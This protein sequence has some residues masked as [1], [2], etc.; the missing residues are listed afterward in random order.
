[1]K[2]SLLFICLFPIALFAQDYVEADSLKTLFD[3]SNNRKV[4]FDLAI[5]LSSLY[6][7]LAE[8]NL[9]EE[10]HLKAQSL[11]DSTNQY[12]LAQITSNHGLILMV[13][14]QFDLAEEKMLLALESARKAQA[15]SLII[16]NYEN[17]ALLYSLQSKV[18]LSNSYWFSCLSY[19]QKINDKHG[20]QAAYNGIGFNYTSYDE[21]DQSL[22]Y[23]QKAYDLA[24]ELD[25]INGMS[26]AQINIGYSHEMLGNQTKALKAYKR[27]LELHEILGVEEYVGYSY[28]LIGTILT[29]LNQLDSS[30]YYLDQSF[31]ILAKSNDAYGLSFVHFGYSV[32]NEKTGDFSSSLEHAKKSLQYSKE[33]EFTVNALKALFQIQNLHKNLGQYR[34]AYETFVNYIELRDSIKNPLNSKEIAG[35]E[36]KNEYQTLRLSDSLKFEQE[37]QLSNIQHNEELKRYWIYAIG[38]IILLVLMI[39]LLIMSLRNSK[40]RKRKNIE[41]QNKNKE[42]AIQK[43]NLQEIHF[44]LE[45]KNN[46]IIDSISYAKRIQSAILPS[47]KTIKEH[48]PQSFIL[49]QPKDIVAGDFYWLE[50]KN[51]TV[52]FAAADCT[53]HGVPGAMVSVVCNNGLNRSVREHQ[54]LDPGQI[55][56]NTREIVIAEFEKSEEDVKDGMDI[57]LCAWKGKELKYAGANNPLWIIRA[58]SDEIEEIKADKQ[59]IGKFSNPLPY[60]THEIQLNEGDQFY[61]FSDGFADQFGGEKGK[62]YKTNNFK[63]LLLSIKECP[64]NEQKETL[65]KEFLQWK[66]S[67]EQLDDICVIGVRV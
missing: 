44:A 55:L 47:K 31:A 46:E 3:Q 25:D 2:S 28:V 33:S 52:L 53:G 6:T 49:Y 29:D 30:Q 57:A 21:H 10:Y 7:D 40:I 27:S 8:E 36:Y 59:P 58:G 62:K 24:D 66:G 63:K 11:L 17:L 45:E 56:D 42:I 13:L 48:L 20:L 15:E 5:E 4:K 18:Y 32:L 12:E 61:I 35:L 51:D 1:M 38:G 37:K 19:Y 54:L 26:A 65:I 41:L 39:L 43:D 22:Q 64:M 16:G 67:L 23:Y 34:K 9:A 14:G 50:Y 60:H